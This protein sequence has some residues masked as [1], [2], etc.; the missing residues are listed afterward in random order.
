MFF[1]A[2][3]IGTS[4]V[5]FLEMAALWLLLYGFSW[6]IYRIYMNSIDFEVAF[7]SIISACAAAGLWQEALE[8]FSYLETSGDGESRPS[9]GNHGF[10]IGKRSPF[11]AEVFR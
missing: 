2:D 5:F 8:I 9:P 11:M 6:Y 10:F 1:F 4:S 7:N 3:G